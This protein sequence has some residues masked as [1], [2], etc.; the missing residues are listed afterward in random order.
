MFSRLAVAKRT[1]SIISRGFAVSPRLRSATASSSSSIAPGTVL[2]G[3]NI[4]KEG[5]DPVALEDKEY[6]EWLWT[7]LDE[8]PDEAKPEKERQRLQRSRVIK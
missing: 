7:L 8:V 1:S 5:K 3:L 6:P 2:K 4:Y